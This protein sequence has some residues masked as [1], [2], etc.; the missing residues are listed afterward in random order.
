MTEE[1]NTPQVRFR[2][3]VEKFDEQYFENCV[4]FFSG[5]TYSPKDIIKGKMIGTLVLRSSNVKDG[6]IVDA[7]NVYV[8]S[9]VVNCSN[10]QKGDIAVVV[11]NG[12][13]SLIGKHAQIQNDMQNTVIGAFMT[14]IRSKYSS[15]INAL[16]DSQRFS[17][18]IEKNLGATINQITIGAFKK[19]IFSFPEPMEQAKIG[20]Y[21]QSLDKLIEQKEK[22]YQTL[23]QFKKAMLGKMFPTNGAD[24]PSIRFS[25]FQ[26][27]WNTEKLMNLTEYKNGKSHEDK[28]KV[29]GKYELINL[30]SIS[31]DGGLKSSGKFIDEAN[32]TLKENDLVMV[33][34]D[35]GHGDLLGRVALIPENNKF[36]LNQRVALLRP[37]E[38]VIPLFMFYNINAHQTYFKLRGA[39]MSQLNISKSCVEHFTSFIPLEKDEQVKIGNL[40][41]KLDKLIDLHQQ[42]L[43]KLKNLKKAFLAKMFV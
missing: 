25:G 16:L 27:S 24:T 38:N 11:R 21:F 9:N 34:S 8:N 30:N 29:F 42:E 22:K 40:L 32:G 6:R 10:V 4:E 18:E 23:Q 37:F 35:V 7:D 17:N 15:Y 13:R 5:L 26:T 36:V 28:Q 33:L 14:G 41:Y 19:M 3:F 39:G 12:S 31:I 20:G 2:G 43:E 1:S